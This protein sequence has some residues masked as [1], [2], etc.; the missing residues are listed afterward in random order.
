M[1]SEDEL[2]KKLNIPKGTQV[3]LIDLDAQREPEEM[4]TAGWRDS[5]IKAKTLEDID[6]LIRQNE[7]SVE[8]LEK[9]IAQQRDLIHGLRQ[10]RNRKLLIGDN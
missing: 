4:V 7:L 2:R 5:Q 6:A 9:T 1:M 10:V 3:T 8:S